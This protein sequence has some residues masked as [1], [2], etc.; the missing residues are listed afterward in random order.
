MSCNRKES[1]IWDYFTSLSETSANC[2]ICKKPFRHTKS[3]TSNLRRHMNTCHPTINLSAR[4]HAEDE[5]LLNE[6][7]PIPQVPQQQAS[8]SPSGSILQAS[9]SGLHLQASKSGSILQASTTEPQQN[10]LLQTQQQQQRRPNAQYSIRQYLTKPVTAHKRKAI[11][12]QLIKMICKEYHP[13]R[14]VEEPEFKKIVEIL[15]P[16]Y[17][18]PSRK[19]VSSSLIPIMYQKVEDQVMEKSS[20]LV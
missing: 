2:G 13:F 20:L 14:T 15:N 12:D 6:D 18:L 11:D 8:T 1:V 5:E 17:V 7:L 19:T 10:V 9:T 4:R 16:G 3:S